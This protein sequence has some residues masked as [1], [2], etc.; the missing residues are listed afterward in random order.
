MAEGKPLH[1]HEAESVQDGVAK[2]GQHEEATGVACKPKVHQ[3]I[4]NQS[5][6]STEYKRPLQGGKAYCI[7]GGSKRN[8]RKKPKTILKDGIWLAENKE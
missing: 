4:G 6:H 7:K 3:G 5:E 1:G 2:D 8:K